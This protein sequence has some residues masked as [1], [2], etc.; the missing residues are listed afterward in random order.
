MV[1]EAEAAVSTEE[2][3]AEELALKAP[4]E[5]EESVPKDRI[6]AV[7]VAPAGRSVASA[8]A[9]ASAADSVVA[10]ERSARTKEAE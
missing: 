1:V 6:E 10:E 8:A 3:Q 7:V 4:A 5:T 9:E 2:P